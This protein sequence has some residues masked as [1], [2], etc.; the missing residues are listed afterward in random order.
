MLYKFFITFNRGYCI[1]DVQSSNVMIVRWT[2]GSNLTNYIQAVANMRSVGAAV[3]VVLQA[4]VDHKK[5]KL[6]SV[7]II[8]FSLGAHAAGL[9][10]SRLPGLKRIIGK[11]TVN[12]S[13][14]CRT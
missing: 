8:G 10:G 2:E 12:L 9:A 6:D 1:G 5:V 11:S 13:I 3:A 4:M 7:T 14:M